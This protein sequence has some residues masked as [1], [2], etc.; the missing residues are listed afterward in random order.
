M[1]SPS[2]E[3]RPPLAFAPPAVDEDDVAAVAET[4]RG[5]WLTSGPECDALEAELAQATGADHVVTL[6]SCTA[7]LEAAYCFLDLPTGA[8][9]GV[10]TWTFAASAT[11]PVRFGGHPVLLDADPDTLNVAT[12]AVEAA[13]DDLDALV[14]VHFAGQPVDPEVRK[15]ADA[16]GVP[17]IEDAAHSFGGHDDRGPMGSGPTY[18]SCWSFYATKNLTSGEGGALAT[19]SAELAAFTREFRLHGLTRETWRR[20]TEADQTGY[21]IVQPGIKANLADPLAALARSQLRRLDEMQAARRRLALRYR[22]Q[23]AALPDVTPVP[24]THDPDS[25]DHLMVVVLPPGVDRNGV[26]TAMAEVGVPTSVHFPPLHNLSW[27]AEH[28]DIGP[29]GTAV[30]DDRAGRVLS[31]PLHPGLDE[32]D[33][34]RVCQALTDALA[35][36]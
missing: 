33:V 13:L 21:D 4:V 7:A 10:P 26:A 27:F 34:D 17:V 29:A 24:G 19:S 9:V 14:I 25:A 31:L 32:A 8:R 35:T 11:A 23:L 1:T 5:G 22:D 28:A 6:N 36:A 18:A 12:E 16:A 30:A 20:F 15:L 2:A 3:H